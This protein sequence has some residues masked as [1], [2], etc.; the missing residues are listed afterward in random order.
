MR[1]S[2]FER[3]VDGDDQKN[4]ISAPLIDCHDPDRIVSRKTNIH[5]GSFHNAKQFSIYVSFNTF[6]S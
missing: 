4:A 6:Y 1:V 3:H 5:S 2:V